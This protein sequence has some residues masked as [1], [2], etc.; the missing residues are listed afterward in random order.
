MGRNKKKETQKEPKDPMK[1]KVRSY[2][3]SFILGTWGQGIQEE[4]L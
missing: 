1:L 3:A 2:H 4:Q